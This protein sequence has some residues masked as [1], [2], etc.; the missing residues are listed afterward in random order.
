VRPMC[1]S[2]R[3]LIDK[4]V[5]IAA[6]SM[7]QVREAINQH[8]KV[9][10][11]RPVHVCPDIPR[12]SQGTRWKSYSSTRP[13][14]ATCA[15]RAIRLLSPRLLVVP[16]SASRCQFIRPRRVVSRHWSLRAA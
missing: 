3:L 2:A 16:R 8:F 12:V 4:S 11:R 6:C 14:S 9:A 1:L 15:E 7:R 13:Q 10:I 5:L